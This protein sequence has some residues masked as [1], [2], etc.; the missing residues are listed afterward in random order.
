MVSHGSKTLKAE[1]GTSSRVAF[2]DR[3]QFEPHR[4]VAVGLVFRAAPPSA[5]VAAPRTQV[6]AR[7][8]ACSAAQCIRDVAGITAA[9]FICLPASAESS[10]WCLSPMSSMGGATPSGSIPLSVLAHLGRIRGNCFEALAFLDRMA[11]HTGI[12]MGTKV[13]YETAAES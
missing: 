8:L 13:G 3:R 6:S 11:E 12:S 2:G 10:S 1:P 5:A 7:G 9:H 4:C